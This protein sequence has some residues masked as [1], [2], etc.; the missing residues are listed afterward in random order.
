MDCITCRST[1]FPSPH[2]IQGMKKHNENKKS[3][4]VPVYVR[5]T[6]WLLF[7]T[8]LLLDPDMGNVFFVFCVCVCV[9][10]DMCFRCVFDHG[11][12]K[13]IALLLNSWLWTPRHPSGHKGSIRPP[14]Q[15]Y[16]H[17]SKSI[18]ILMLNC[19]TKYSEI[20]RLFNVISLCV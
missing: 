12:S 1:P 14:G 13:E 20:T 17:N 10:S 7:K 4:Y 11:T 19:L 8:N 15:P 5:C 16:P 18:I 6:K 3:A 2:H 9:A